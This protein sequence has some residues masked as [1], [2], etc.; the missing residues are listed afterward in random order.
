MIT[1]IR[2]VEESVFDVG[3]DPALLRPFADLSTS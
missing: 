2:D 1:P 3:T